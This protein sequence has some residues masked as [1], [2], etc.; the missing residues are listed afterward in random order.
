MLALVTWS[1][2]VASAGEFA[3]VISSVEQLN[4]MA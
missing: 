4:L 2:T 3:A 1:R